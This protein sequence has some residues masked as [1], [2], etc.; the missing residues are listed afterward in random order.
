MFGI[1]PQMLTIALVSLLIG[2]GA[3]ALYYKRVALRIGEEVN[4]LEEKALEELDDEDAEGY[5]VRMSPPNVGRNVFDVFKAWLHMAKG[6]RM[7]KRGYIKW[8]K[9]GSRLEAPK[10]IKPEHKGAGEYE[11]KDPDT[12][13]TYFFPEDALVTD[14]RTSGYVA[15]H[16]VGEAEPIDLRDPGWPTMDSDRV[17][18]VLDLIISR[19]PDTGFG[20]PFDSAVAKYV[21]IAVAG[22]AI[23]AVMQMG[24]IG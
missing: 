23:W 11:Y 24:V 14:A 7:A 8:Y 15:I 1:T 3:T 12:D 13:T 17:Q 22:V 19:D 5:G 10:W 2:A 21:L 9:V 18:T 16:K 20:L 4:E 6:A